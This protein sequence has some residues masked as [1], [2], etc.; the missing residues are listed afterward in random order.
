[1]LG[2]LSAVKRN[3]KYVLISVVLWGSWAFFIN[4]KVSVLQAVIS[5]LSQAT[6]SGL[7][8][9]VIGL[10]VERISART[11]AWRFA[12]IYPV[13]I[14]FLFVLSFTLTVHFLANTPR[15]LGTISMPM[16]AV[17][18]F[19]IYLERKIRNGRKAAEGKTS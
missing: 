16:T 15:I 14:T 19:S 2:I 4:L 13:A 18:L 6:S 17:L 10:L 3:F 1:M 8:T 11:Q 7:M 9:L 5:G 12:P